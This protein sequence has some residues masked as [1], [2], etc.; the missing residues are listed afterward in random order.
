MVY[1]LRYYTIPIVR[2]T[3]GLADTVYDIN[4]PTV[5]EEKKVGICFKE[6]NSKELDIA[7]T[8]A[9]NLYHDK[10]HLLSILKNLSKQDFSWKESAK[11]YLKLYQN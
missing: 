3:G 11:K 10:S 2:T 5:S 9:F 8:K 1:I 7:L 6:I 4:D